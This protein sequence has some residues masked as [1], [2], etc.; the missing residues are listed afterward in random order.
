MIQVW[1]V[2]IRYSKAKSFLNLSFFII[3]ISYFCYYQLPNK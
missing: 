2:T 3:F 1:V